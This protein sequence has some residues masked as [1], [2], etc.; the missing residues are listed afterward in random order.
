[1]IFLVTIPLLSVG[2]VLVIRKAMPIFRR[3]FRKYDA[4]NDSVQENVQAMRV[5]KSYVREDYEKKKFAAAAE[6]VCKDFTRAERIM[7][8]NSPMMQFCVYAGMVFVLSFGSYAVITSR[9]LEVAV[10]Q[11][12]AIVTYSFQILMSLMMLSMVFVMI[13]MSMESAE[14]IVEVLT[15]RAASTAPRTPSPR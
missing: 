15:K 12:S 8:L 6:D 4:L 13:T 3:V 10:G 2:L 14:R 7:A 1:M 9:G 5:V 11:M